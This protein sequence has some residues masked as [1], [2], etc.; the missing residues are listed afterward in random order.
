MKD[1]D[2]V[3]HPSKQTKHFVSLPQPTHPRT[4]IYGQRNPGCP[5][6]STQCRVFSGCCKRW[7][8]KLVAWL[9]Q[10]VTSQSINHQSCPALCGRG[11]WMSSEVWCTGVGGAQ[12]VNGKGWK[13]GRT[14]QRQGQAGEL[15]PLNPSL[16]PR[17]ETTQ[18]CTSYEAYAGLNTP[19]CSARAYPGGREQMFAPF[20][21]R[22]PCL[23]QW[24][25]S[26]LKLLLERHK[27]GA[28]GSRVGARTLALLLVPYHQ[29]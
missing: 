21:Q 26:T 28:A 24:G 8:V 5:E 7:H 11:L 4:H 17:P 25:C 1:S 27:A 23:P 22:K 19:G 6:A 2:I 9:P 16:S 10:Q 14:G 13:A 29:R 12:G 18:T 20:P 3:L 15:S